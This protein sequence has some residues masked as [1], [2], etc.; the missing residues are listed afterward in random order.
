MTCL[1]LGKETDTKEDGFTRGSLLPTSRVQYEY[2]ATK[3]Q[4]KSLP[5][6]E[7]TWFG[8]P[9]KQYLR[10]HVLAATR[11]RFGSF[12]N[13]IKRKTELKRT[14]PVGMY[15]SK[16]FKN[17]MRGWGYSENEINGDY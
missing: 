10:R 13:M 3:G 8:K 6:I 1:R 7:K 9:S 5:C 15:N 14:A 4:L 2:A 11:K 12:E 17:L 16:H